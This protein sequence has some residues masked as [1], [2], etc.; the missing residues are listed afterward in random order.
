MRALS[1]SLRGTPLGFIL[2]MLT[3]LSAVVISASSMRIDSTLGFGSS[4]VLNRRIEVAGQKLRIGEYA[5]EF[6]LKD[7]E[8]RLMRLSEVIEDGPIW[9][10]FWASWCGPCRAEAADTEAAVRKGVGQGW[11]HLAINV[12]EEPDAVRKF[13]KHYTFGSLLD[14]GHR[15]S[16]LYGVRMLPT[17]FFLTSEGVIDEIRLGILNF[18]QMQSRIERLLDH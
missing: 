1:A 13:L 17:H 15:V 11:R 8:G 9:I 18:G 2:T 4:Q 5:P 14:P 7:S 6:E 16:S 10:T 3:V 12:G